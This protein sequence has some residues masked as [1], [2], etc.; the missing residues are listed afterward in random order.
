MTYIL[1]N[2]VLSHPKV[3]KVFD[4]YEL[5]KLVNFLDMLT[6]EQEIRLINHLQNNRLPE[7]KEMLRLLDG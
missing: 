4:D 6:L 3:N 1:K 7:A 2:M 5:A